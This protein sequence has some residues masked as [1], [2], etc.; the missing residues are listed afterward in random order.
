MLGATN[1]RMEL[2]QEIMNNVW[3]LPIRELKRIVMDH[4]VVHVDLPEARQPLFN[5]FVREKADA[6]R[7]LA[8]DILVERNLGARQQ[9]ESGS[10]TAAKPRVMDFLNLVVTSLSSIWAGRV[11]TWCKL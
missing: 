9:T 11:A 5:F 7:W 8:F 1:W 4:R 2:G 6:E 10:P 3:Y